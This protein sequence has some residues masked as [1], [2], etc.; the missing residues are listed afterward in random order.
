MTVTLYIVNKGVIY[1]YEVMNRTDK[2]WRIKSTENPKGEIIFENPI[3]VYRL[4]KT[5]LWGDENLTTVCPNEAKRFAVQQ[6]NNRK[7]QLISG[8]LELDDLLNK[9]RI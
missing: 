7:Q 1:K 3:P 4:V 8:Q 9:V 6:I 5:A 2:G